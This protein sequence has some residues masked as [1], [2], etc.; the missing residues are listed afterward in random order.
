MAE[1]SLHH[2]PLPLH[3]SIVSSESDSTMTIE[4]QF[5]GGWPPVGQDYGKYAIICYLYTGLKIDPD[6]KG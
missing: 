3:A 2:L 6:S 1:D 5:V 4:S